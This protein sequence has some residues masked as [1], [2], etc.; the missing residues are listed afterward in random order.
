MFKDFSK[1]YMKPCGEH[2]TGLR[3]STI[4]MK[5]YDLS[6]KAKIKDTLLY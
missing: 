2:M 3:I 6:L 4:N 1:P 5:Y